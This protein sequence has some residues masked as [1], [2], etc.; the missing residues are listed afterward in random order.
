MSFQASDDHLVEFSARVRDEVGILD[1]GG[2]NAPS[3]GTSLTNDETRYDLR[4]LYSTTN[5]MND[6]HVTYEEAAYNPRPTVNAPINRYTVRNQA[7][8][9][10]I[11]VLDAPSGLLQAELTD[12][13]WEARPLAT[14]PTELQQ[15]NHRGLGRELFAG[16]RRNALS[17]EEGACT[18][19][20][21]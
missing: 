19:L 2:V 9:G 5:W 10:D 21:N 6:A 18:W 17:A 16:F 14:M 1:V 3:A 15:A 8:S 20:L 4:S 11:I 12:A 7:N 13:E